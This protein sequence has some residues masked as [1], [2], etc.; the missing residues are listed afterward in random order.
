MIEIIQAGQFGKTKS[1]IEMHRVRKLIF[2]D[3]MGWDVDI[4]NDELEIDDF[5]LPETVYILAR[6]EMMR[7]AGVWRM[8]PTTSPSMIRNIWPEFLKTLPIE[9]SS[10]TWELSRFGVHAYADGSREHL[11]SVNK[12][13]AELI[14]ALLKLCIMTNINHVYTMYN[15]QIAKSV[16]RIGFSAEETSEEILICGK[17]S[18]IGRIRTDQKALEKVQNITGVDIDLSLEELPPIIKTKVAN[19]SILEKIHA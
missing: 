14:V 8:L 2:K 19:N 16:G 11:R 18:V 13:T 12:V 15:Q 7:V 6:D 10:N 3:R 17:P 5:D 4:S 1:L 9:V